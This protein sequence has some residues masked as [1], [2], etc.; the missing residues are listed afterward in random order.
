VRHYLGRVFASAASLALG[1][2]VYDTQCG[3]KVFRSSPALRAALSR[4]FISRWAFDVELLGRLLFPHS[5]TSISVNDIVEHPLR[6]WRHTPGS[7]LTLASMAAAA[8]D[9]GLIAFEL[10]RRRER[11]ETQ[12]RVCMGPQI[13]RGSGRRR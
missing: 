2:Q 4:P 11:H 3:G 7:K 8:L 6:V 10:G 13:T 1:I 5:G 12:R 9:L